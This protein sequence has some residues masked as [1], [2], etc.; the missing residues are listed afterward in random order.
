M[1]VRLKQ[2][3]INK[4]IFNNEPFWIR[5]NNSDIFNFLARWEEKNIL[6]PLPNFSEVCKLINNETINLSFYEWKERREKHL[7]FCTDVQE[8]L[9]K[10]KT[11]Y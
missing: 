3:K 10:K 7:R 2:S 1:E 6:Q 8:R 4:E 11:F 9:R 5:G